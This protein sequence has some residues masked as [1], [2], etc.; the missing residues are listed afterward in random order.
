VG[1]VIHRVSL[2]LWDLSD[3]FE[4]ALHFMFWRWQK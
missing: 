3:I 1:Q 2:P 4:D